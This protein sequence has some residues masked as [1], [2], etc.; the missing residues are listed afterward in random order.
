MPRS[1]LLAAA[2]AAAVAIASVPATAHANTSQEAMF[3]DD[4]QLVYPGITKVSQNLDVLQS[5]GVDRIRV[6][7]FWRL[8][9]VNAGDNRKPSGDFSD[10]AAYPATNWKRYDQLIRAANERGMSVNL[11]ISGPAPDWAMPS[12]GPQD[13]PL[14]YKPN[15]VEWAKFVTAAAHRYDGTYQPPNPNPPPPPPKNPN[16]LLDAIFGNGQQTTQ[17]ATGPPEPALP[18]VSY[19]SIWNEPNQPTFLTPQNENGREASPRVYRGLLDTA[20]Q[21][22]T[23]TGHGGDTI[24]IG[25]TA[26]RGRRVRLVDSTMSPMRFIR[27]LYCVDGNLRFVRGAQARALGCPTNIQGTHSFPATHPALFTN[28]GYA[29]HPYSLLTPP[30]V[31]S[32]DADNVGVADLPR[33]TNTLD[34][35]FNRYGQRKRMP[36]FITE[37][38]YQSKPPD[39]YGYPQFVAAAFI[40]Q[41]EYMFFKNP[42]VRSYQQ[43]LLRDDDPLPGFP[44]NSPA[45]WST[46]Q[47]GLLDNDGN[48]KLSFAAYRIPLWVAPATRRSAGNVEV[49]GA[50]RPA[51]N[52][53]RQQIQV[54]FQPLLKNAAWHVAKT[55]SFASTR[56]YMDTRLRI[57]L[58]GF[59]RLAW[60]SPSG[61]TLYSRV[62]FVSIG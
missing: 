27:G 7:L 10:P 29:H 46:F 9:A 28:S 30:F 3:Q 4:S 62:Q 40:N 53:S 37:F 56:N 41:S 26:P 23:A 5:L 22:L 8:V 13:F 21:A 12:G 16:P 43:F 55:V 59:V 20:F 42:R 2:A 50:A 35:I 25:E 1:L 45:Y 18:R 38:G 14:A 39:P 47:T 11:N 57:P 48:P 44:K 61:T 52:F 17:A 54:Q 24:L 6:T 34:G 31:R 36:L 60:Q 32:D 15:T 49:W 51:T 58:S 19:W 33:I